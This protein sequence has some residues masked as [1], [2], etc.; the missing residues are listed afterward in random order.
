[1]SLYARQTRNDE[2]VSREW[3]MDDFAAI[4]EINEIDGGNI[5]SSGYHTVETSSF[6]ANNFLPGD[7]LELWR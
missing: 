5:R 2:V 6:I 4:L 1:M 3:E 7:K